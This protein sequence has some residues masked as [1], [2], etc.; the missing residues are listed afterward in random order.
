MAMQT[1]A[2]SAE[3]GS[4][5]SDADLVALARGGDDHAFDTLFRRHYARVVNLAMRLHGNQDDAEDIA[6]LAFVRAH[7]NL[8]RMRDGQALLA[9]LYRTVVN[10]VR[11]RA[12]A[13]K[14]K[15]WLSL[16]DLRSSDGGPGGGNVVEPGDDALDPARMVMQRNMN[17]ALTEAIGALPL[18]FREPVVMHHLEQM[19]VNEIAGVLGV[20][21]GTVKSRLARGRARLRDAM[22]PWFEG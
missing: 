15:P 7:A 1:G 17:E 6:Q 10:E 4:V 11:D 14:R 2:A 16:G 8:G 21:L 13:R 9:W 5:M 20:P 18:E 12:K 19:D 22:A 3:I